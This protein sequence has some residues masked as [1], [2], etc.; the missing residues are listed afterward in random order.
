MAILN[1]IVPLAA[2]IL[3]SGCYKDFDP[4]IAAEPVLC[5]NALI[6]AGEP[7]EVE[8][9]RTWLYNN[10]A[11]ASG[12][13][14]P[15]ATVAINVNGR[16]AP[17][18]YLPAE[19]DTIAV[20]AVSPRYGTAMATVVVPPAPKASMVWEG[21]LTG[22]WNYGIPGMTACGAEL[23]LQ[24]RL[25]VTDTDGAADNYYELRYTTFPQYPPDEPGTSTAREVK[26]YGGTFR[27]EAEPIFGEHIGIFDSAMGNADTYGCTFFTDRQFSGADY[28]LRLNF[29]GARADIDSYITD[30]HD[31]A[32]GYTFTLYATSASYY[33]WRA[34]LWN[35]DEG[36]AGQW[37]DLGL[38]EPLWAYSNVST[39]AGIV[40]A[41]T[42]VTFTV[43]LA[44]L[45]LDRL[46][47][48]QL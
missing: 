41:R 21:A 46:V 24:G 11:G 39:G 38:G 37:G 18:D 22:F 40:A 35:S 23:E 20:T 34:Y 1:K 9:T 30:S 29:T 15:D 16:P 33:A 28:T 13:A 8:V 2:A 31:F 3:L 43:D 42:P 14:V 44:G 32:L 47:T 7:V 27:Y 19:G 26:F 36:M 17:E 6:T 5:L 12:N 10:A 48:T 4:H 25:T 45:L